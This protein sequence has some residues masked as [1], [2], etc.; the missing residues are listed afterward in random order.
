M[1]E[2]AHRGGP[3]HDKAFSA[4]Q[5][6]MGPG[7]PKVAGS[8][9]RTDSPRAID[10]SLEDR[11]GA[12]HEGAVPMNRSVKAIVALAAATCLASLSACSSGGSGGGS[13]PSAAA[14]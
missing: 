11:N 3:G 6:N 12:T 4:R 7:V 9:N 8:A 10:P 13:T 14:S 1:V 2:S 5:I